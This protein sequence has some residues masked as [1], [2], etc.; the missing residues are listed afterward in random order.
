MGELFH[1]VIEKKIT[2]DIWNMSWDKPL[3]DEQF[4]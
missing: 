2:W 1:F 3:F 4:E